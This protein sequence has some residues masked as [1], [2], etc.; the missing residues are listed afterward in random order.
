[1]YRDLTDDP[2]PPPPMGREQMIVIIGKAE[3]KNFSH[4]NA[5]RDIATRQQK[6]KKQF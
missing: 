5:V 4:Q 1:M 2:S 6:K 3:M